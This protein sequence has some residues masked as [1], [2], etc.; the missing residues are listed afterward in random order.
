MI[1]AMMGCIA[2]LFVLFHSIPVSA[3]VPSGIIEGD[4]DKIAS[5]L[6]NAEIVFIGSIQSVTVDTADFKVERGIK[7]IKD[8]EI[9]HL[10]SISYLFGA[11]CTYR[12]PLVGEIWFYYQFPKQKSDSYL[13]MPRQYVVGLRSQYGEFS[14]DLNKFTKEKLGYDI[15]T[16]NVPA[17]YGPPGFLYSRARSLADDKKRAHDKMK[18]ERMDNYRRCVN[19]AENKNMR[20][21]CDALK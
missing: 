10:S 11:N 15:S 8:G 5:A 14:Q 2:G 16:A 9:Y 20:A 12:K 7:K 18:I 3:C 19:T 13:P 21:L 17:M 6:A 1:R 4:Y